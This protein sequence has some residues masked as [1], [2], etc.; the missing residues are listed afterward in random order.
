MTHN[1]PSGRSPTAVI[2]KT[3]KSSQTRLSQRPYSRWKRQWRYLYLRFGRLRGTPKS[4]SRGLAFGVFAGCFPLLGLQ[5]LIGVLLAVIF[6]GHKL[7]A[8]AGTWVSNPLTYVPIFA[9]NY[10][11]GELLLGL[12]RTNPQP[13]LPQNWQSWSMLQE[14]GLYFMVTLFFGCFIVGVIASMGTYLISLRML[15]RWRRLRY[16]R[17]YRSHP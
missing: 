5:T 16:A 1:A 7:A 3:K 4:I 17:R 15:S 10:K 12:G 6:R 13:N 11:V 8:A 9:F 14:S 2:I